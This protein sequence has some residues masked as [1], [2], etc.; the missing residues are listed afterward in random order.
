MPPH[1]L[2]SSSALGTKEAIEALRIIAVLSISGMPLFLV[3]LGK[4]MG[5]F[6]YCTFLPGGRSYRHISFHSPVNSNTGS[7]PQSLQEI[8]FPTQMARVFSNFS[9]K[10]EFIFTP[11]IWTQPWTCF[12][13]WNTINGDIVGF[14]AWHKSYFYHKEEKIHSL[15]NAIP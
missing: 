8:P 5:L 2:S 12:V 3:I 6:P 15:D 7:P 4:V 1:P 13:Q 11:W 14:C 9:L 10:V